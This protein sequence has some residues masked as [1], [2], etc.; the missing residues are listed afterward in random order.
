M[1]SHP[2]P[3]S[4]TSDRRAQR[5]AAALQLEATFRAARNAQDLAFA[6]V[7]ETQRVVAYDT[8]ALFYAGRRPVLAA[9][10][11]VAEID[12]A[13]PFARALARLAGQVPARN[14]SQTDA[15]SLVAVPMGQGPRPDGVLSV[16]EEAWPPGLPHQALI[17]PL[18]RDGRLLGGLILFRQASFGE[19]ERAAAEHLAGALAHA[20]SVFRRAG[21]SWRD[22]A[23]LR[24]TLAATV[25]LG[26]LS[27]LPVRQSVLA[28]AEIVPR[29]AAVVAAPATGVVAG[30]LVAPSA[31][32]RA[33]DLLFRLDD[34]ELRGKHEVALRQLEVARAELLG[35]RQKAFGADKSRTEAA[36]LERRVDLRQAETDYYRELLGRAEVRAPRDGIAIMGDPEEWRGRP[37]KVGEKV[38]TVASPARARLQIWIP[39]DD[40]VDLEPGAPVRLFMNVDPLRP[41][42]ARLV[43]AGYDAEMSPLNVLSYR[44]R[45]D[46]ADAQDPPR[47]GLKGTAKL[48]GERVSLF[49]FV[50]RRPLAAMRRI[51]G[52]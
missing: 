40:A 22:L 47:L 6:A 25:A 50:F 34:T 19:T 5:L 24:A 45:A 16:P 8:A 15:T 37:V 33:G 30:I 18:R 38:M 13:S 36:V 4:F 1:T 27:L 21:R 31:E 3:H 2:P 17:L 39:V 9:V 11:A 52:L 43:Q 10:S 46:L 29:D 28:P 42:E 44:A 49:Y 7:N 32:I 23:T 14:R 41:V 48:Y 26:L 35:A 20:A 12:E 51:L